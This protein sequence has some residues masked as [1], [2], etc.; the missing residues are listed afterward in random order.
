MDLWEKRGFNG[1]N[2]TLLLADGLLAIFPHFP[3]TLIYPSNHA[4]F[5]ILSFPIISA[6]MNTQ[7]LSYKRY[8]EPSYLESTSVSLVAGAVCSFVTYPLE[9]LKTVI[10]HQAVGVG[11]RGRRGNCRFMQF[12]SR[13]T[14]LLPF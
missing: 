14:I 2:M 12:S 8:W 6:G 11:F 9:F 3:F 13:A 1:V 4:F 5:P 10:Q 7:S